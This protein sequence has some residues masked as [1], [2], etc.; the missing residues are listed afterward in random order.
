MYSAHTLDNVVQ[1]YNLKQMDEL[2][3]TQIP[4][5][6]TESLPTRDGEVRRVCKDKICCEFSMTFHSYDDTPKDKLR[7]LY[8]LTA[9]SGREKYIDEKS[10]ELYCAVVACSMNSADTCGKRFQPSDDV[11]PS[12]KFKKIKINMI[13]ELE[14]TQND[15]LVM[16]TNVDM[17]ILPLQTGQFS[18]ERSSVYIE[19]KWVAIFIV[20]AI[21]KF[22]WT[23]SENF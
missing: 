12:I 13:V 9:F 10:K 1:R 22:N 18:F 17:S 3:I 23:F 7:Y 19:N 16:P 8:K 11:V 21:A 5:S 4:V 2:F 6:Y 20:V 14:T 15:Y